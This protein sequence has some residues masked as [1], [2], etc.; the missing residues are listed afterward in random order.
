M[1]EEQNT[2]W[3]DEK[4]EGVKPLK[5]E[6]IDTGTTKKVKVGTK[7]QYKQVDGSWSDDF[8]ENSVV[9]TVN[10]RGKR[11][12]KRAGE[13]YIHRGNYGS[14]WR[15]VDVYEDQPVYRGRYLYRNEDKPQPKI[16]TSKP[17]YKV[18]TKI[19]IPD[20]YKEG[21]AKIEDGLTFYEFPGYTSEQVLAAIS[22]L[23]GNSIP[24]QTQM[25]EDY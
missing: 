17:T 23:Y 15:T 16:V 4:I 21:L 2:F 10:S 5:I 13:N 3:S 24:E 19:P 12:Y 18:N 6:K 20:K 8:N 11:F 7:Q 25:Y 14:V 22:G 1:P 9:S